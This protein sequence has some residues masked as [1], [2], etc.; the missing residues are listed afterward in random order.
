CVLTDKVDRHADAWH[1]SFAC[2]AFAHFLSGFLQ[3]QRRASELKPAPLELALRNPLP[4]HCEAEAVDVKA[5][6]LLDVRDG[7]KRDGLHDAGFGLR[8][9]IHRL[10]PLQ[11]SDVRSTRAAMAKLDR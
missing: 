6:G 1:L 3:H 10:I 5:D 7:E 11:T 9:G 2:P 8:F 4:G